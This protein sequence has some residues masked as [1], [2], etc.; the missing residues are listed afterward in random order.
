M[1]KNTKEEFLRLAKQWKEET[2]YESSTRRMSMN[3][4]YQEIIGMGQD[5]LPWIFEALEKETDHWF[6]A[7]FCI[8]RQN[9]VPEEYRGMVQKMADHWLAWGKANGYKW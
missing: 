3:Y 8:T 9:P 2:M 5:A 6:W 1:V 4:A 7:L